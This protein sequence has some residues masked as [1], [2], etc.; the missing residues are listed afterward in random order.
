MSVVSEKSWQHWTTFSVQCFSFSWQSLCHQHHML[1]QN[2]FRC[3]GNEQKCYH[4]TGASHHLGEC[5]QMLMVSTAVLHLIFIFFFYSTVLEKPENK[6]LPLNFFIHH[7]I[8]VHITK[9]YTVLMSIIIR[10][11]NLHRYL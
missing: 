10:S 6:C 11:K 4:L 9:I 8:L 5:L 2:Y 1:V 3:N 7:I